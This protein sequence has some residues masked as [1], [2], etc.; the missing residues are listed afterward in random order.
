MI[1][2][3][4]CTGSLRDSITG[5]KA[6]ASRLELN[7]GLEAGGL[8]PSLGVAR[9]VLETVEIPVVVMI[10]PASGGFV[11]S[12]GEKRAMLHD[13]ESY[14]KLGASGIVFGALNSNGE[15]DIDFTRE[16]RIAAADR[17]IVFSRAFDLTPDLIQ[18][19]SILADSGV[20]RILTSGGE[21]TAYRGRE[22]IRHLVRTFE[23][24]MEILP[25]SGVNAFNAAE[26][27]EY[28]GCRWLHGSF[29]E[30]DSEDHG[31]SGI[32]PPPHPGPSFSVI[33]NVIQALS[34]IQ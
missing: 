14:L 6:G 22:T 8:T 26:L 24:D 3:E 28:T 7:S 2:I 33:E 15:I 10:R 20:N 30:A 17:E 1:R 12:A 9:L 23:P 29:T 16:V 11:Y 4:V 19:A 13:V 27:A 34:G 21:P 31:F 5:W 25:G 32:V 18:S